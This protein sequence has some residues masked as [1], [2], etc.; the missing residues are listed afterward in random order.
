M[1]GGGRDVKRLFGTTL[2]P[3]WFE[4]GCSSDCLV[5]DDISEAALKATESEPFPRGQL[6]AS[7]IPLVSLH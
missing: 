6:V 4:S 1:P 7:A 2:P 3:I 5:R